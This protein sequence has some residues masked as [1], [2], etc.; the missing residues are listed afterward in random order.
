MSQRQKREDKNK[1]TVAQLQDFANDSVIF[2]NKC[3]KPDRNG[4]YIRY[5]HLASFPRNS[6]IIQTFCCL[7]KRVLM[8]GIEYMKILQACAM[9]FLVIGFIGYIIKLVFI[10]INNIILGS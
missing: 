9:G 2:F 4:K 7:R 5:D 6:G 10:P 8:I 3:A 1:N